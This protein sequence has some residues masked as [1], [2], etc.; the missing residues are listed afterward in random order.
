MHMPKL[1]G[2]KTPFLVVVAALGL[3]GTPLLVAQ[4]VS[5]S[6]QPGQ[7]TQYDDQTLKSFASAYIKVNEIREAYTPFI[8]Q[9][10]NPEMAAK[11]QRDANEAMVK[12][13]QEQ[14]LDME[15]Y[16]ALALAVANDPELSEKVKKLVERS[17]L[18]R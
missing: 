8:E 14:G 2:A 15:T 4:D 11:Y 1:S 16:N 6:T 17:Q 5:P 13:I 12:A 9:T 3:A 18:N 10:E 7:Q